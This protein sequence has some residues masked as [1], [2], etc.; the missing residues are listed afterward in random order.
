MPSRLIIISIFKILITTYFIGSQFWLFIKQSVYCQIRWL[1]I[2]PS[3]QSNHDTPQ[4]PNN[5]Q[6]KFV[7]LNQNLYL[8]LTENHKQRVQIRTG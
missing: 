6:T 8:F 1:N 2:L 5:K 3:P 7:L 4:K